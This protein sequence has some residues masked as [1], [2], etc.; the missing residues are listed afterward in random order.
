MPFEHAELEAFQIALVIPAQR[1]H[2]GLHRL[3][4][5]QILDDVRRF[6]A[7]AAL[8]AGGQRLQRG[9]GGP[10][11]R[12]GR[13]QLLG[14]QRIDDR[15]VGRHLIVA[16]RQRH[17]HAF[18]SGPGDVGQRGVAHAFRPH[19]AGGQPGLLGLAQDLAHFRVVTAEI[20][21]VDI[22][23]LQARHQGGEVFVAGG[24]AFEHRHFGALFF[25]A[26]AHRA[27]Q[28]FAIL[29]LVVH[30]GDALRLD[31]AEDVFGGGRALIRVQA[32]GAHDHL[33]AAGGQIGVGGRRGNHDHAFVFINIGRRLGGRGAQVADHV[34][35]AV[36]DHLVGD[37]NRLFRV[38]GVV[39]FHADQL[40]ALD[41][42]LGVNVGNRLA[43]AGKLHVA[44]LRDRTG[45]RP[46]DRHLDVFRHGRLA[47]G[48]RNTTRQQCLT[49]C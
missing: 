35:N 33:V 37:R 21:E 48:H 22:L 16:L 17:Q 3:T 49:C 42:A 6:L 25:Q 9:I 15:L 1:P 5:F 26:V 19:E 31:V 12:A 2:H 43:R 46:D 40:V 13:I 29:L 38:A 23:F 44:I 36:V 32:G 34:A 7:A 20:H 30:H 27:R 10:D 11:E 28:A 24:D 14:F 8:H 45:H 47:H 39:V 18:R 4:G 41:A